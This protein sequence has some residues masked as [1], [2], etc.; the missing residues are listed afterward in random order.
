MTLGIETSC[1]ETA[2][3]VVADGRHVL[4]NVVA[5]QWDTHLPFGGVVPE[6][7]SRRHVEVVLPVVRR[8]LAESSV[9]PAD[10]DLVAAT[11]GPGLPGAL[12]VGLTA[13]KALALAWNKPLVGVNHLVGHLYAAF[14]DGAG[15]AAGDGGPSWPAVALIV[16]GGHSDLLYVEDH[17]RYR[18]LGRT[19]DDAAGEAFDK[20]AR[21]LGLPY[22]GG[23]ALERLARRGRPAA[24]AFPRPLLGAA[25]EDSLDFSFSGLKTAVA[26]H[27]EERGRDGPGAGEAWLADVAASFQAAVVDVL[28]AR[29]GT[30]LVRT[31]ARTLVAAGGVAANGALRAALASLC[32]RLGVRLYVPPPALCTDNAAM[33]ACAGAF[34]RAAGRCDDLDL[35]IEP[36][37]G[38]PEAVVEDATR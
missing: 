4:A 23:P 25:G 5:S 27:L 32:D 34:A 33:I 30:A 16:S 2:A 36:R 11:V 31:G 18:V 21:L 28:V 17:G 15:G 7:A 29:A 1:D 6:L 37:L 3:A 13:A 24:V 14:L 26:H 9:Q 20:V 38:W 12:L 10:V 22:P 19:R 35:D 8:A